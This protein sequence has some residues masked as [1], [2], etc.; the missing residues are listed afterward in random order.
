MVLQLHLPTLHLD[1]RKLLGDAG[2]ELR[3]DHADL[4]L[5]RTDDHGAR[6]CLRGH[7]GIDQARD[8]AHVFPAMCTGRGHYLHPRCSISSNRVPSAYRSVAKL[9]SSSVWICSPGSRA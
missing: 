9:P 3:A 2:K 6:C 8:E 7:V 5:R 1:P 4:G